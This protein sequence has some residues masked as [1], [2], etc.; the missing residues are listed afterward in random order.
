MNKELYLTSMF[1]KP[2]QAV[3]LYKLNIDQTKSMFYWGT[4]SANGRSGWALFLIQ[5]PDGQPLCLY[6]DDTV[7]DLRTEGIDIESHIG[8]LYAA[9]ELSQLNQILQNEIMNMNLTSEDKLNLS[10]CP[11]DYD[12]HELAEG[13]AQYLI[14]LIHHEQFDDNLCNGALEIYNNQ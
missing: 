1:I 7:K 10:F 9:L 8:Q 12:Y 13:C 14:E 3:E 4:V 2:E 11:R 5:D 6:E